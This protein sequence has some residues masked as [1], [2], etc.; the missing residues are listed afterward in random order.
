MPGTNEKSAV[1]GYALPL[2]SHHLLTVIYPMLRIDVQHTPEY[3]RKQWVI[4]QYLLEE[5]SK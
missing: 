1:A 3:Y 5:A 4:L 2:L